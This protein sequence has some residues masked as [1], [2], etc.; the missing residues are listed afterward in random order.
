MDAILPAAGLAKR[1]RGIPKFLLPADKEYNT[2]LEI[3]LSNLAAICNN[4]YLPTR[5]ELVPIIKSLDFNQEN[6]IIT[7]MVTTTMCETVLKTVDLSE[8]ESFLLIMPDT[9][10]VGQKP[11]SQLDSNTDFCN[12]ACWEIRDSQR[13]KLGE[14]KINQENSV[15][16]MVDKKP[17]N[18]YKYSWGALTFNKKLVKYINAD[19]P[20][21]GYAVKNGI[22]AGEKVFASVVD[23]KYY[24]C[25]TPSEY[26]ELLEETLLK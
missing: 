11:Y 20:H 19:E 14:V 9:F 4:I 6:L 5:P 3:H 13:G 21:I 1:M 7:E 12:L 24:D 18:G 10:F 23:G 8:S 15:V 25:G 16:D 17:D 2:L 22:D 26:V